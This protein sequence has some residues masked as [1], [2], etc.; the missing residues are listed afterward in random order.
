MKYHRHGL[1]ELKTHSCTL[2]DC[3][4]HKALR[5]AWAS[6]HRHWTVDDWKHISWSDESR[7]QL[8]RVD[9]RVRVWRQPH[10]FMAPTCQQRTVQAGL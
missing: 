7:F 1:L 6:Q 5:L 8:N 9:G 3:T 10:E 4:T 2:V